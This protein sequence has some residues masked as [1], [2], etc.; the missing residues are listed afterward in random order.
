MK[1]IRKIANNSKK[2]RYN[3]N[4]SFQSIARLVLGILL[5][6]GVF[7]GIGLS[8]PKITSNYEKRGDFTHSYNFKFKLDADN[9]SVEE[10][11]PKVKST[12]DSLSNYLKQHGLAHY[13]T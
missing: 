7:L 2:P 10:R 11:L 5:V 6:I 8:I 3:K 12:A 1:S 9:V 4:F 13:D